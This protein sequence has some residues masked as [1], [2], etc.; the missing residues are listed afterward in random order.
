MLMAL[1]V[2]IKK[3]FFAQ[4]GGYEYTLVLGVAALSFAFTAQVLFHWM[5]CSEINSVA[6]SGASPRCSSVSLA[7]HFHSF[8]DAQHRRSKL[9]SLISPAEAR[10]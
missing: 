3:G 8:S 9:K 10:E 7:G 2:H 5:R 6:H 1:T 4:N